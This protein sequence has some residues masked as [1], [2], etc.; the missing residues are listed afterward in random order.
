VEDII[1]FGAGPGSEKLHG[2]MP[3]TALFTIINE[4]L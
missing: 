3:N 1:A 2:T 4:I